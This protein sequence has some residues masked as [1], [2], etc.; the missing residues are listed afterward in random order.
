MSSK[1][2][3]SD[4]YVSTRKPK[5]LRQ[6]IDDWRLWYSVQIVPSYM[7]EPW[8]SNLVYFVFFLLFLMS[9]YTSSLYMPDH[10]HAWIDLAKS[11]FNK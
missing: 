8:E 10:V 11:Y 5:T 7:L 6:K 2:S 4:T 1:S 3:S 9:L